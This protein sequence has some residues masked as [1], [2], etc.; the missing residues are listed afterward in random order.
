MNFINDDEKMRDFF[1]LSKDEFLKSYSYLT[2]D[3]YDD[4]KKI[5]TDKYIKDYNDYQSEK[6]N[7]F[8]HIFKNELEDTNEYI[9]NFGEEDDISLKE[10]GEKYS[11]KLANIMIEHGYIGWHFKDL[12]NLE[13]MKTQMINTL[14]DDSDL[15]KEKKKIMIEEISLIDNAKINI[16]Q[17]LRNIQILNKELVGGYNDTSVFNLKIKINN[18]DIITVTAEKHNFDMQEPDHKWEISDKTHNLRPEIYDE[19]IRKLED[20]YISV[21]EEFLKDKYKEYIEEIDPE[22][23]MSYEDFRESYIRDVVTFDNKHLTL[24]NDDE[25]EEDEL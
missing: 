2:E 18:E 8:L 25:E 16:N 11:V 17:N 7:N 4:T 13:N 23:N 19:I 20:E 21:S 1:I 3:E 12:G 6:F 9:K 24:E 5:V 14:E 22:T 10:V 15:S